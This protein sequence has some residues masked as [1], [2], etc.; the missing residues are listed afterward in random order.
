MIGTG[1]TTI[2]ILELA[3]L[4]SDDVVLVT[5]AAGGIGNLLVQAARNAGAAVVGVAGGPAKVE[6]VRA[7]GAT[8][9]VDYRAP[10]WTKAVTDAFD[11]R[12]PTVAFD[13]VGG[14]LGRG[15]LELLRPGGRLI[16]FGWSSGEPTP[17]TAH[18]LYARGLTASVAIGPR[19]QQRPGGLRGLEA[20]ALAEAA[21]G[22]LVPLV[23]QTFPLAHAADAHTALETRAT[24]GKVVLVP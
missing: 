16:M 7:L 20:E 11:G 6:R 1:R 19:I 4:T 21:A 13:G 2:A 18:D 9:A 12:A 17:L 22:R 14:A 8:A 15:A 23:G 5:A 24:M 3:E 10:D